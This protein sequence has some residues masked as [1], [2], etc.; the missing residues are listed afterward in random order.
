MIF[1]AIKNDFL[2]YQEQFLK[3]YTKQKND[4]LNNETNSFL[5]TLSVR[6]HV[7][8]VGKNKTTGRPWALITLNKQKRINKSNSRENL[9]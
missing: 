5:G 3:L 7:F 8:C 2:G 4:L 9:K 6:D 1:R